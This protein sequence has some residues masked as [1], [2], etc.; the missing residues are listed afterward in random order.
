MLKLTHKLR[1]ARRVIRK[2]A[3]LFVRK[4]PLISDLAQIG[5][6]RA[7]NKVSRAARHLLEH[8]NI[9]AILGGN[10]TLMVLTTGLLTP[11][12]TAH[13]QPV[14]TL[15]L[16]A[17]TTKITT[18]VK[19][20]YP[21]EKVKINQG[22][23]YFHWGLDLDGETG[24]P[25]YPIESGTVEFREFSRFGY[26]NTVV[27]DHKDGLKSRYAHL[28]RIDVREGDDVNPNMPLGKL[29]NT[30][31]STGAHLHLEIYENGRPVN[32][33]IFLGK[34]TILGKIK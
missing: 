18:E 17:T 2:H 12:T 34:P 3:R 6:I 10:I 22:F 8:I 7:G 33:A 15:V 5:K 16:P 11:G 24:D 21:V 31:R 29:G 19:I 9:K 25:V 28:S 1:I 13:E 30:G 4:N 23:N 14:E 20:R 32:P 27:V 26:G